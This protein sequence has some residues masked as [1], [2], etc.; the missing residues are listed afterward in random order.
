MG[1][2]TM[3]VDA[4]RRARLAA[5]GAVVI[6]GPK[7]SGKTETAR[8][9]AASVVLLDIDGRGAGRLPAV[10]AIGDLAASSRRVTRTPP[11][12]GGETNAGGW[13]RRFSGSWPAPGACTLRNRRQWRDAGRTRSSSGS[14]SG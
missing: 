10:V 3:V 4:E 7:A 13:G 14:A 5:A 2:P 9:A 12:G 8:R 11:A 6:E 1:L